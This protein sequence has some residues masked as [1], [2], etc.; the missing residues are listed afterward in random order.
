[1]IQR[2][3]LF[4]LALAAFGLLLAACN[5]GEGSVRR[6]IAKKSLCTVD[7]FNVVGSPKS[8]AW[9]TVYDFTATIRC[10]NKRSMYKHKYPD[11]TAVTG[12]ATMVRQWVVLHELSKYVFT[13][14]DDD[15]DDR[16]SK[17]KPK[18]ASDDSDEDEDD[19]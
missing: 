10:N 1:M 12:E 14:A 5:P 4:L 2:S 16:G 8:T 18:K 7:D 19:E 6:A 13:P 17:R 15:D 3:T 9:G 11:R